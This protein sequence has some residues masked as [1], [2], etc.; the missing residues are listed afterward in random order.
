MIYTHP[1]GRPTMGNIGNLPTPLAYIPQLVGP[2]LP[3]HM[4]VSL[5]NETAAPIPT[6]PPT[7]VSLMLGIW[8]GPAS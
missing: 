4:T 1:N 7:V 3:S 5:P 6:L 8:F 2:P